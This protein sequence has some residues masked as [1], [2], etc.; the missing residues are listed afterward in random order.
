MRTQR[1]KQS[2]KAAHLNSA[3]AMHINCFS[4]TEKF[5]ENEYEEEALSKVAWGTSIL[6]DLRISKEIK[7]WKRNS[8]LCFQRIG[9][10]LNRRLQVNFIEGIPNGVV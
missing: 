7:S 4:P 9:Q 8:Y 10:C 3:L 1:A 6:N 2:R 5:P